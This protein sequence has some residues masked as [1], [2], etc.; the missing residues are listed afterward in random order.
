MLVTAVCPTAN[1]PSYLARAIRCFLSQT[2]TDSELLV[3]DDGKEPSDIPSNPRIRQVY[4][5]P[6]TWRTLGDKR[7]YANTL[8]LGD[9]IW[10][11]DDDDWSAPA[12][13]AEQVAALESGVQVTGYSSLLFYRE[14]DGGLF[15]YTYSGLGPYAVGT[16]LCYRKQYWKDHQ[17]PSM[18]VG[19]DSQFALRAGADKTLLSGPGWGMLVAVTLANSTAKPNLGD[20]NFPQALRSEFPDAFFEALNA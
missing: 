11:L 16:S 17:F 5:E 10:H 20:G 4:C 12:R 7:N 14:R 15:K 1:R 3:L 13:M 18:Q 8:A 19:E 2:F 6:G 9:I